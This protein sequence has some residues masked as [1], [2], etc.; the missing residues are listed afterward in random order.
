MPK[1]I[2]WTPREVAFIGECVDGLKQRGDKNPL[3]KCRMQLLHDPRFHP[4]FHKAH[5]VSTSKF[6]HGYRT[7]CKNKEKDAKKQVFSDWGMDEH[8]VFDGL[9]DNFPGLDDMLVEDDYD[10]D[11]VYDDEVQSDSL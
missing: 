2:Q 7:Y 6:Q 9:D 11:D 5:V 4:H 8:G 10:Y 1:K 3:P